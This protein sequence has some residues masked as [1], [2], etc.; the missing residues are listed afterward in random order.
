[1]NVCV[2]MHASA[3]IHIFTCAFMHVCLYTCMHVSMDTCRCIE[4]MMKMQTFMV[5]GGC[6]LIMYDLL[7]RIRSY[8]FL[9][10]AADTIMATLYVKKMT[11]MRY[12]DTNT[13]I[14]YVLYIIRELTSII[15][16]AHP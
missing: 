6:D 1:M 15:I 11:A 14:S 4:N 5:H 13:Y 3:N 9:T 2:S 8:I 16:F 12:V 10:M 7:Q